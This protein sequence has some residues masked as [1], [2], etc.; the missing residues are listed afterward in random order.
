MRQEKHFLLDEVK[1]QIDNSKG[2]F[3]IMQ[4]VGLTANKATE[5]RRQV[6]K[7][8]GNIEVMRKLILKKAAA[9]SGIELDTAT[10]PGHIGVV[11]TSEDPIEM[12][13]LVV[14]FGQENS[15]MV[16]VIG[17]RFDGQL[18]GAADVEKLSKLPGRDGMRAE[19]LGLF[20]APM[21]QTL[22]VVEAIL[23]SVVYC[24]DNK[25]KED[26]DQ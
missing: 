4:Y 23:S 10:M 20:E 14:K 21:A 24:L 22:A 2:S 9:Q 7:I 1:E 12:T 16:N 18:Y 6:R 26:A 3:V 19:L 25:S 11:Y 13:K 17:G 5:L 8:G 15:K